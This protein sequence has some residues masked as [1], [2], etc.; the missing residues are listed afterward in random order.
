MSRGMR[1][2]RGLTDLPSDF[3]G[4]VMTIGNF[5]GVHTGHQEI[6][7]QLES[8]S[9]QHG[10]PSLVMM[11]EPQPREFFS[12]DQAPARLAGLGDKLHDLERHGVDYVFCLPF[13]EKLRSMSAQQFMQVLLK[14]GLKVRHLI[15]GDD[16]RFGCDRAGDYQALKS[17]GQTAGFSVEDTA[18]YEIAGERVSSTRVRPSVSG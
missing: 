17:F 7:R 8:A 18:T 5:D 4:C 3:T 13:N 1:L 6:L 15:V 2:V 16:F 14:D 11:F 9:D 10:L 12:P